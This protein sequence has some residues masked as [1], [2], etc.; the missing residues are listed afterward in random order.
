MDSATN[1]SDFDD[2]SDLYSAQNT[3]YLKG[4]LFS[5]VNTI[6]IVEVECYHAKTNKTDIRDLERSLDEAKERNNEL[7]Q[8]LFEYFQE[9]DQV[10]THFYNSNQFLHL[11]F[12]E[13]H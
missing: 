2:A 7:N 11:I 5:V 4:L 3:A 13:R 1:Q 10:R 12:D 9:N 8:R 6:P